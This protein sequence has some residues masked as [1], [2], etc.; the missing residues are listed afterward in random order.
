MEKRRKAESRIGNSIVIPA[1]RMVH[2]PI[3]RKNAL[4]LVS[5]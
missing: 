1:I 2:E 3:A 4:I 5:E